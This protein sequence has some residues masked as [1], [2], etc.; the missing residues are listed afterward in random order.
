MVAT[1]HD[2]EELFRKYLDNQCSPEEVRTLLA[3]FNNPDN[4]VQLR[5]LITLSL[6]NIETDPEETQWQPATDNIFTSIKSQLQPEKG[7]IVPLFR[8]AWIRI[9]AAVILAIGIFSI[10]NY[11]NSPSTAKQEIA[12]TEKVSYEIV[13]G[14]NKAILTLANGSTVNLKTAVNDIIAKQGNTD[15]VRMADGRLS[16]KS[17]NEKPTNGLYNRIATPRGG[18]YEVTLSDGTVIWLNA[19]S[20]IHFP[21]VFTGTERLVEITGE[22]Y[23]EVAKNAEMPFKVKIAD[24]AEIEVLGTHFNVNA[25]SDCDEPTINATLLEGRVKI[26]GLVRKD[27]RTIIPG[28]GSAKR[29]RPDQCK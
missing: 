12:E 16:Y 7:K 27:S 29:K 10:Y 15:I 21:V 1:Q 4:E 20:S 5:G 22:A 3:Y 23:F 8:R 18:Q 28:T 14:G 2:M 17:L 26:T 24:K 9:A 11:L 13:P 19:A 25:Y 6:E